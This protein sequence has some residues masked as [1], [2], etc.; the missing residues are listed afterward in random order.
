MNMED[1]TLRISEG[2]GNYAMNKPVFSNDSIPVPQYGGLADRRPQEPPSIAIDSESLL[3]GRFDLLGKYGY[4]ETAQDESSNLYREARVQQ[5]P[6]KI[7]P[8]PDSTVFFSTMSD[9]FPGF[10][11]QGISDQ[12]WFRPDPNAPPEHFDPR[13]YVNT[14]LE[15]KDAYDNCKKR[16]SV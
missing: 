14:R 13:P 15:A 10:P 8:L 16:H 3:E 9:R 7:E 2:P 12:T 1:A 4:V 5:V 6:P 11:C